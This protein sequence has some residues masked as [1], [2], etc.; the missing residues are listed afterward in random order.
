MTILR[1]GPN[2]AYSEGWDA[3]FGGGKQLPKASKP[4]NGGG[5][6]ESSLTPKGVLKAAA[7]KNLKAKTVVKTSKKSPVKLS[8]PKAGTKAKK[9]VSKKASSKRVTN[10]KPKT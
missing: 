8:S 7:K 6:P 1:V 9:A 4:K 10:K 2:S 5:N 3:V